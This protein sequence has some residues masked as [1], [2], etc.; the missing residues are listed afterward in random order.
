MRYPLRTLLIVFALGLANALVSAY[1][2]PVF[3]GLGFYNQVGAVFAVVVTAWT[4]Y[5]AI[6]PIR[7]AW[8]TWNRPAP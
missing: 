8:H 5:M 6:E 3:R 2:W 4:A 7:V 1:L